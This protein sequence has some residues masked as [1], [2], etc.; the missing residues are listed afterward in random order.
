MQPRIKN[1]FVGPLVIL[2]AMLLVLLGIL[3][4]YSQR[5][6]INTITRPE[7]TTS[8]NTYP[9]PVQQLL[10]R[11]GVT[12]ST[13]IELRKLKDF[14][15]VGITRGDSEG[16]LESWVVSERSSSTSFSAPFRNGC[17]QVNSVGAVDEQGFSVELFHGHCEGGTFHYYHMDNTGQVD[18]SMSHTAPSQSVAVTKSNQ[19]VIATLVYKGTCDGNPT[20]SKAPQIDLLGATLQVAGASHLVRVPESVTLDCLNY[21][22]S[23]Y[24][25][26][27]IEAVPTY[28]P[29]TGLVKVTLPGGH[30]LVLDPGDINSTKT[31]IVK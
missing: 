23:A 28:N 6:V 4:W 11:L 15:W 13:K 10:K 8:N 1:L 24:I 3:G 14:Y 22:D 25:Y 7:Q 18:F 30:E 16:F 5:P 26:P 19:T 17:G 31:R 27:V 29:A 9:A 21:Y 12:P 2:V 20:Q